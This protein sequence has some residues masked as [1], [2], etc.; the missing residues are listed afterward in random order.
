MPIVIKPIEKKKKMA[1][2]KPR[3]KRGDVNESNS[4]SPYTV[5]NGKM[6]LDPQYKSAGGMIYKGR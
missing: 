6:V 3:P 4:K 1:T 2:P 5:K